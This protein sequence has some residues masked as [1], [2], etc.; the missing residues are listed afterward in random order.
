MKNDV[1]I[2][3]RT[4]K[5]LILT[6]QLILEFASLVE[7]GVGALEL[8]LLVAKVA[9]AGLV[10]VDGFLEARLQFDVSLFQMFDALLKLPSSSIGLK[11]I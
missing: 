10:Q 8:L 2:K 1:I 9:L 5:F 6:D 4:S 3:I 11:K 7:L